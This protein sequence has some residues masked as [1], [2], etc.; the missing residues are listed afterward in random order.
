MAIHKLEESVI[1]KIAAGEIIIQPA[2][3]LKEMLEN[4]IDAGASMVDIVIKDGGLKFL[5]ITDNGKG[6]LQADLPL[7]CERF[8]TSKLTTY[9]DLQSI[10]TYGFRGEALASIS[11]VLRVSVVTKTHDSPLAYKAFFC[12]GVL[13]GANYRDPGTPRPVAGKDGTL[14]VVEDLFYNVPTRLRSLKSKS[15]ELARIIDVIGRYAVHT[16]G[17]GISCKRY[18]EAMQ[19]VSTRPNLPLKERIRI[20][21]GSSV[22]NEILELE[23]S[24]AAEYGLTS[25]T[26]CISSP[27][28]N[29]KKR[30]APV[31]FINNRLVTCDPLRKA[32]NAVFNFFL[33]K[34]ST[35][36]AYLSLAI[37]PENL[38]VNIHPTKREVRFLH[39]DEIIEFVSARV[40]DRLLQVDTTRTFKAQTLLTKRPTEDPP[41]PS[42]SQKKYRQENKMVRVDALQRLINTYLAEE[43]SSDCEMVEPSQASPPPSQV[44]RS[45]VK[46]N[47]ESIKQLR[48]KLADGCHRGL[49]HVFNNAVYVGVVDAEKRLCCFQYDVKLYMCNYAVMLNEFYYQLALSEFC[50]YGTYVLSSPQKLEELLA[51]LYEGRED[52]VGV[53]QIVETLW[54][55]RDMFDEYFRIEFAEEDGAVVIRTLPMI[56]KD[57]LPLVSKLP[58]FLYR[59]GKVN[60]EDESECLEGVMKEIALLYLPEP[61]LEASASTNHLLETVLFP[62]I[63]ERFVA[64]RVLE[65]EVVQIADLPGLYRVFE[66]C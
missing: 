25:F 65:N 20:I 54:L 45:R 33:P 63:R 38:D 7:L 15:D 52:L 42:Q 9:E 26:G 62:A 19:I 10:A 34:G 16:S 44:T 48:Q 36:F 37:T 35:G 13:T 56:L 60:I 31:I 23:E 17:V 28:Y 61:T 50:N 47:L 66:R 12:D 1:N 53:D 18:G 49:S 5:Q 64:L 40:H 21:Y 8:A 2:N 43:P 46:V 27:N 3:A 30:V 11:H 39:E 57:L 59:L 22:A 51:G 55:M 29:N 24:S 32:V 6:I 58:Y 4:S 14:I 41:E